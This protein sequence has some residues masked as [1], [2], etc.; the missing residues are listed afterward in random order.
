MVSRQIVCGRV[1]RCDCR[2]FR[3]KGTSGIVN[4]NGRLT[5]R[6]NELLNPCTAAVVIILADDIAARISDL[7]L[8]VV[9]VEREASS[10]GVLDQISIEI[11]D[12]ALTRREPI[13]R[14]IDR[15]MRDVVYR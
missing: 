2:V 6:G 15:R 5:R 8:F 7:G 14:L 4:K 13:V 3:R 10:F 11:I 1:R 9:A 12:I